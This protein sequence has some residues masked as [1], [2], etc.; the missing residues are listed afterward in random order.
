ME[1]NLI[2]QLE[3]IQNK[4]DGEIGY[5]WWKRYI[6]MAYWNNLATTLNFSITILTVVISGQANT[7]N[8]IPENIFKGLTIGSLILSTIN[9]FFSPHTKLTTN[10]DSLNKYAEFGTKL[11]EIFYSKCDNNEDV[12]NKINNYTNLFIEINK[13]KNSQQ[14]ERTQNYVTDSIHALIRKFWIKDKERWLEIDTELIND[15]IKDNC[16]MTNKIREKFNKNNEDKINNDIKS[17][18]NND[19]KIET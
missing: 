6:A 12:K 1:N 18:T 4:L 13:F 14:S 10:M 2:E 15:A 11:E 16:M 17:E 8:M 3:K 19:M 9:T 7:N 5:M